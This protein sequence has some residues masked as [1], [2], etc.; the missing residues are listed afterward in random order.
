MTFHYEMIGL[1]HLG[2]SWHC[3]A[4]TQ[5]LVRWAQ[6][7]GLSGEHLRSDMVLLSLLARCNSDVFLPHLTKSD[8]PSAVSRVEEVLPMA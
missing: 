7:N 5:G 4:F 6:S 2:I 3:L 1:R 8:S